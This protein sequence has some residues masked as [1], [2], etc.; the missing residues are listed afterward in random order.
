M[1]PLL[2][3]I[4]N[5][6]RE[7]RKRTLESSARAHL[8]VGSFVAGDASAAGTGAGA[9]RA[10]ARSR[11][12]CCCC[13]FIPFAERRP[14]LH[15]AHTNRRAHGPADR[16]VRGVRCVCVR[17]MTSMTSPMMRPLSS[18]RTPRA[19]APNCRNPLNRGRRGDG[20]C[21]A[22]TATATATA[23]A[24]AGNIESSVAVTVAV[25]AADVAHIGRSH[26]ATSLSTTTAAVV[27]VVVA[28]GR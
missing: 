15:R 17:A 8:L 21:F 7:T 11:C 2:L 26:R 19:N 24:D 23:R 13:S 4:S 14:L 5:R 27:V 1:L 10:R 3:H 9:A 18:S 22:A 20:A 28:D 25:A 6:I 12:C 16:T